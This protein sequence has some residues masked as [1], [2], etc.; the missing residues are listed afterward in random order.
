MAGF[1]PP[2]SLKRGSNTDFVASLENL[3]VIQRRLL[4]NRIDSS[5]NISGAPNVAM[6]GM[7]SHGQIPHNKVNSGLFTNSQSG[8]SIFKQN[9]NVRPSRFGGK[10][11]TILNSNNN[12]DPYK[13]KHIGSQNMPNIASPVGNFMDHNTDLNQSEEQQKDH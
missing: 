11:Q 6:Q 10:G 2:H 7:L 3:S 5:Y 8:S 12:S 13:L 9:Q 4:E 1:A